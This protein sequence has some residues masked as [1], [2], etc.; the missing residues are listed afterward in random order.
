MMGGRVEISLRFACS[1]VGSKSQTCSPNGGEKW[2]LNMLR[3]PVRR[4]TRWPTQSLWTAPEGARRQRTARQDLRWPACR[5]SAAS[6]FLRL[7]RGKSRAGDPIYNWDH[8]VGR[9]PIWAQFSWIRPRQQI[10]RRSTYVF[11]MVK[12][13]CVLVRDLVEFFTA[14]V[15]END[16]RWNSGQ[17]EK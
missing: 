10:G 11:S 5:R 3:S 4:R 13:R 7:W 6:E 9:P 15:T 14:N 17:L 12:N 8:S 16:L 1:V 2:W